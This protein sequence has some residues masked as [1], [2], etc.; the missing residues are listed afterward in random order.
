M[1]R[2]DQPFTFQNVNPSACPGSIFPAFGM[3]GTIQGYHSTR[4]PGEIVGSGWFTFCNFCRVHQTL[5][6]TPAMEAG[7][8]DHVWDLAELLA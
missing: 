8:T 3:G 1:A 4:A 2:E 6:V 5:R 7:I